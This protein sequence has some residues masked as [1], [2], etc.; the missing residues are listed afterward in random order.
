VD[1]CLAVDASC[2]VKATRVG[3]VDPSVCALNANADA[4]DPS[5]CTNNDC[6]ADCDYITAYV[7]PC[8]NGAICSDS[9][10]DG[11]RLPGPLASSC[12]FNDGTANCVADARAMTGWC[13]TRLRAN[14]LVTRLRTY[15]RVTA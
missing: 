12:V 14:V 15:T 8:D 7:S 3:A 6:A 11:P 10:S 4:C 9:N 13:V 5:G 2:T 1:E